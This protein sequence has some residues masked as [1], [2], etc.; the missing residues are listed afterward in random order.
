MYKLVKKLDTLGIKTVRLVTDG[1]TV[2]KINTKL[3]TQN[4]KQI[5][6]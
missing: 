2:N 1:L 6:T 5:N 4:T 3:K